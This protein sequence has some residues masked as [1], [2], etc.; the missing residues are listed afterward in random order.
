MPLL[1]SYRVSAAR[2]MAYNHPDPESL[3]QRRKASL[4]ITLVLIG[5][6]SL[7]SCS[8]PP[9]D[10][11]RDEYASLE[12][13]LADWDNNPD[14]CR[15]EITPNT[16]ATTNTTRSSSSGY[17]T[18]YYGPSY[19]WFPDG[20]RDYGRTSGIASSRGSSSSSSTGSSRLGSSRSI[21]SQSL[22]SSARAGSSS[23]SISRGGFGSSSSARSSSS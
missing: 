18:R 14:R 4:Q 6:V 7:V 1:A 13:C 17:M 2:S 9:A 20:R 11:R 10:V 8:K 5:A 3:M 16:A 23:S 21:G 15:A 12:N 19:S 22:S